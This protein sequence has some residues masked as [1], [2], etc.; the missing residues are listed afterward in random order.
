MAQKRYKVGAIGTAWAAQS[1][2]PT[3]ASYPDVELYAVCSARLER[4]QAAAKQFGAPLAFDDYREMLRLPELDIVYVG[5]PVY[6]HHPMTVAA[7]EAG[8]HILCEKPAAVN[9][10]EAREML[11]A[12]ERNHVAHISA[13]T[14]RFFPH[15]LHIKQ[16]VDE[17]F[18]GQVRHVS[19]KQ[20]AGWPVGTPSRPWTWLNDAALGGG[21]LGAMGSHY[22]DLVRYWFGEWATVA[23]QTR[24]WN[25]DLLDERGAPRQATADDAFALLGT[26][27]NGG[28]VTI[29]LGFGNR[30]G[31]GF[32]AEIYGS[33]GSIVV[34]NDLTVRVAGPTD[35]ALHAVEVPE[36]SF[37]ELA[38][39]SAVPRFGFLIHK[40][41][42]AIE[43]GGEQHP[44]LVDS[45]RCQEVIDAV[46]RSQTQGLPPLRTAVEA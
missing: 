12:A 27:E 30:A 32:Q 8:K 4:A 5:A 14:M 23:G 28:V 43:G 6:L 42:E 39:R 37:P 7:A 22:I 35:R 20:W 46:H 21:Y 17:G 41:I 16:L 9:A 13:F 31:T 2:L 44:N 19:I 34:D 40:L 3:F 24:T 38:A 33:S 36:P 26:L 1:P 45:L 25:P 29:Q 15:T 11:E 18:I 10:K